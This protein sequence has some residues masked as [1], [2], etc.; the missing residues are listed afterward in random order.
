MSVVLNGAVGAAEAGFQMLLDHRRGRRADQ[1]DAGDEE[2][3]RT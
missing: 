1:R 2:D 3:G